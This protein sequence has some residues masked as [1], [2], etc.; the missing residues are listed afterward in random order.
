MAASAVTRLIVAGEPGGSIPEIRERIQQGWGAKVIDHSGASEIGA[1]GF[2]SHDGSGIHV[3]ETEFIAECLCFDDEHPQGRPA[4][5]GEQSEL[6]LTGLGRF[7]GPAIRYRTGD[8]VRGFRQHDR[9]C[10]FLFL[11]GGVLGRND[12]MMVIRGVN[13]F[14]SSIESIVRSIDPVAEFRIIANRRGEMDSLVVEVEL[15]DQGCQSLA[16]LFQ[17]RL[18]MRVEVRPVEAGSLPRFEA[19]ARRLVD[20]RK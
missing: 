9:P 2:G 3:I 16:D 4:D 19:K 20:R 7:G 10:R 14:P 11:D 12:D 6:V 13:V 1:W 8:S 18:A 15:N 17:K 5:E